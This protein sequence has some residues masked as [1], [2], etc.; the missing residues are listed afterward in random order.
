MNI[1]LLN[2]RIKVFKNEPVE[3]EIGNHLL[4]WRLF[5][6]CFATI[7]GEDKQRG[8]EEDLT[9]LTADKQVGDFTIR[10]SKKA[11]LITT[12]GFRVEFNGEIYN[13][14]RINH[15]SYKSGYMKLCCIKET[16]NEPENSN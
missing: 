2:V 11:D 4:E 9:F 3:D 8:K 6:E 12:D 1:G 5:Y 10:R 16:F 14:I 7:S 15:M 13:I